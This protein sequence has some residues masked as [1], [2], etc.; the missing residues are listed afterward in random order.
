M[1]SSQECDYFGL[2]QRRTKRNIGPIFRI[3]E[4]D[5]ADVILARKLTVIGG[6][7]GCYKTTLALNLVYNTALTQGFN[8]C[9]LSLEMESDDIHLRLLVLHSHHP[10]FD[11]FNI[12]IKLKSLFLDRLTNEE[13][14][15]LFK[16]VEPDFKK[17]LLGKIIVFGP[18][19]FSDLSK[20]FY[21]LL[22]KIEMKISS[23]QGHH[24][25]E[26]LVIDYIQ[27]LARILRPQLSEFSD[28]YQVLSD[29]V[30]QAKYLTQ[31]YNKNEGLSIVILSQL[32]RSS[33]TAA[34]ER[35]R[36]PRISDSDKYKNIFD[37]TSISESSEIVNA[38]DIVL[39]IYTDDYLKKEHKAVIQLLKN[40][41][42]ETI[43]E[44]IKVLALPEISF[45]GNVKRPIVNNAEQAR[46]IHN[47]IGGKL[48]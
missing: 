38:A 37:L 28:Q 41:F 3:E 45:I 43:E 12:A 23:M 36:N 20:G 9:F 5:K 19:D 29:F 18:E 39:T 42:G 2:Y 48:D 30:R 27:L 14:N 15:F 47:L 4:L 16:I 22:Q 7:S 32:N 25:L 26:L 35:F 46:Y 44:G 10:K 33:Y 8:C 17:C 31:V 21:S 34:K 24:G 11:K 6:F 13:K 40:R 1:E